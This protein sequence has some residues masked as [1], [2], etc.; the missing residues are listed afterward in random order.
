[1]NSRTLIG[2]VL[3][4]ALA[5]GNGCDGGREGDR[6]NP[7]LSHDDCDDGLVCVQPATCV[8]S[9]CCPAKGGASSNAFCNGQACPAPDAAADG[10]AD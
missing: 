1:M 8:E 4:G 9:Y 3:L 6:C 7:N 2:S 10:A 5:F